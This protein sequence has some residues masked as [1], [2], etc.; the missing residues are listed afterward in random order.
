MM[1]STI[2]ISWTDLLSRSLFP[3]SFRK[4]HK[5]GG[6]AESVMKMIF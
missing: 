4:A 1:S 3:Q 2:H 5:M 6:D